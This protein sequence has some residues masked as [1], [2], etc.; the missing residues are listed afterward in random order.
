MD[1]FSSDPHNPLGLSD[2]VIGTGQGWR[3]LQQNE[4]RFRAPSP[5][6]QCWSGCRWLGDQPWCGDSV[7]QTY[8]TRKPA[9]YFVP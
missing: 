2:D 3:L 7:M 6:I 5:E 1:Y 4:I 9:D 8:R